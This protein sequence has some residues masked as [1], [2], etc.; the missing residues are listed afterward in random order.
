MGQKFNPYRFFT[1]IFIP[2]ALVRHPGISP[3]AKLAYGRL[4]R[5]AGED[6]RCF[7]AVA[8]LA[9]EIGVKKRRAQDCLNELEAA[10]FIVREFHSGSTT[11]YAF[12]WHPVFS[13]KPVQET[14]QVPVQKAASHP[15]QD[16]ARKENHHQESQGK[17]SQGPR[18]SSTSGGGRKTDT[19]SDSCGGEKP[20]SQ[21]RD[22]DESCRRAPEAEF[23]AR[24]SER[25]GD[26]I[27][28]RKVLQD[29][30]RELGN[31]Q[32]ED[33]LDADGKA[34]TAPAKLTNPH[35][36][37][38]AMARKLRRDR[39]AAVLGQALATM[40]RARKFV[41]VESPKYKPLCSI[42]NEGLCSD[43]SYCNCKIGETRRALDTY[44]A[45]STHLK[46]TA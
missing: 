11:H 7:P 17:E 44:R 15:M 18:P 45:A 35:G 33:F 6:G 24:L 9:A 22:D 28:P 12:L 5:Y 14:A 36:H 38:R 3:T 10:G 8:T 19:A 30:R 25:H 21:K 1:G 2:E 13:G 42:C 39:E 26:A 16:R 46:A 29:V 20:T 43:G 32:L 34:T 31:I 41:S 4:V 27:D 23:C 37:Y 40:E